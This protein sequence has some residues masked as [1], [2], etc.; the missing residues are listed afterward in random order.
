MSSLKR[1]C[2]HLHDSFK[3]PISNISVSAWEDQ[4][5]DV[6]KGHLELIS[7]EYK[8]RASLYPEPSGKQL[9]TGSHIILLIWKGDNRHV[10]GPL[11]GQT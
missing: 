2:Q 1:K 11:W 3:Q 7:C 6:F 4:R 9:P 8:V 10:S 5:L